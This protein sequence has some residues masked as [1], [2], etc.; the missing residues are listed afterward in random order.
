MDDC[1]LCW[2]FLLVVV[3]VYLLLL[4]LCLLCAL[5]FVDGGGL[6]WLLLDLGFCYCSVGF[7]FVCYLITGCRNVV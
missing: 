1:V 6:C 3:C 4:A 5:L 7:G 2:L